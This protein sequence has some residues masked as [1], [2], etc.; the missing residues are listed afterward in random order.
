MGARYHGGKPCFLLCVMN[1]FVSAISRR[2]HLPQTVL[3]AH[4]REHL[5]TSLSLRL[6]GPEC[7]SS[8]SAPLLESQ[9]PYHFMSTSATS[10]LS[11]TSLRM[12][13]QRLHRSH[14]HSFIHSFIFIIKHPS[15]ARNAAETRHVTLL[16]FDSIH[17]AE[18]LDP[19]NVKI[20]QLREALESVTAEQRYLK[21]RE[22]R[23]RRSKHLHL[24]RTPFSLLYPPS[25]SVISQLSWLILGPAC[26][27][28]EGN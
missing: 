14:I 18:H 17:I 22:T 24:D 8:V 19:V 21:A 7:T 3:S 12:V 15:E 5:G 11:M 9:K 28:Q 13:S 4:W 23:H 6:Q 26:T 10:P 27:W 1:D 16:S 20:A 25:Q 2:W